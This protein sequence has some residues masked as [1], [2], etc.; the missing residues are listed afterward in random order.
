MKA[1]KVGFAAFYFFFPPAVL[2]AQG[3][4][5]R[6]RDAGD[7]VR[8]SIHVSPRKDPRLREG[9][10]VTLE[11]QLGGGDLVDTYRLSPY[12]SKNTFLSLLV[13][14][15]QTDA[16]YSVSVKDRKSD[17]VYAEEKNLSG[18]SVLN[19]TV[20]GQIFVQ[21]ATPQESVRFDY[22]LALW[23]GPRP[24]KPK[25]YFKTSIKKRSS[26]R[27][28][29]VSLMGAKPSPNRSKVA[30]PPGFWCCRCCAWS[31]WGGASGFTGE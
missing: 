4:Y 1:H 27:K 14:T 10:L 21:L 6:A 18:K 2:F 31:F 24:R 19:F 9:K 11:G 22:D 3:D 13:T 15:R 12:F 20:D 26:F 16:V 28:T 5:G 23:V 7:S 8:N 25:D 30:T 17:R 29:S